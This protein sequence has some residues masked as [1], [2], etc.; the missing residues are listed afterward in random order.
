MAKWFRLYGNKIIA[1]Y[2]K[3]PPTDPKY[4]KAP[5]FREFVE[6]LVE[7]P[8]SKFNAHWIPM[9][10]QCMP[11]HIKYTIISRLDTLSRDSDLIFKTLELSAKLPMSH[12]TQ[13]N[14]KDNIVSRQYCLQTILSQDNTVSRNYATISKELLDELF[15]IYKFDFSLFNYKMDRYTS[16]VET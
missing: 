16:Y 4:E 10:L 7:L 9:Y 2:R 5:T 15:N 3:T 11:C 12:V 6:Y 13:G 8:I 14:T 1:N